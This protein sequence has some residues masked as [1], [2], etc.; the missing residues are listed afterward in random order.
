M[1]RFIFLHQYFSFY[2][3]LIENVT[4]FVFALAIFFHDFILSCNF[5]A[6]NLVPA[7]HSERVTVQIVIVKTSGLRHFAI[8]DLGWHHARAHKTSG[9]D[10]VP[11]SLIPNIFFATML[12]SIHICCEMKQ[13]RLAL[14]RCKLVHHPIDFVG[15]RSYWIPRHVMCNFHG[16]LQL[17]EKYFLN[18]FGRKKCFFLPVFAAAQA[19][20]LSEKILW[21][22]SKNWIGNKKSRKL[23]YHSSLIILLKKRQSCCFV[24]TLSSLGT[25]RK[26]N[27]WKAKGCF[28]LTVAN[29]MVEDFFAVNWCTRPPHRTLLW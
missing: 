14:V 9:S 27:F 1:K 23:S 10:Y 18:Y 11:R 3:K 19:D 7:G 17:N 29:D 20:K 8:H 26:N 15:T 5:L 2:V 4:R 24:G 12:G 6:P 16:Y 21:I 28:R 25:L 13:D 22:S